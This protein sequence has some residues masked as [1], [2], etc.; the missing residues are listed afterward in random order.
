[1]RLGQSGDRYTV[2]LPKKDTLG[3]AILSFMENVFNLAVNIL[4]GT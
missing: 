2:E 1:M 3:Q 4:H